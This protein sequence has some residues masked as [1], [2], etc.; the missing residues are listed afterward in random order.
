[1]QVEGK[2]RRKT[3]KQ[4]KKRGKKNSTALDA[5]VILDALVSKQRSPTRFLR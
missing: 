2:K 1:V 3:E 4:E 5:Y